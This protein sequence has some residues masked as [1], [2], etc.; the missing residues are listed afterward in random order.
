MLSASFVFAAA[1][2]GGCSTSEPPAPAQVSTPTQASTPSPAPS[3]YA[4][5]A[6]R[7][8]QLD[9]LYEACSTPSERCATGVATIDALTRDLKTAIAAHPDPALYAAVT[10]MLNSIDDTL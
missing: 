10:D 9:N 8:Q 4:Q 6:L 7:F 2:L 3:I 1:L 5:F